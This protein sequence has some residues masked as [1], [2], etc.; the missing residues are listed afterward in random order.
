[1]QY[2]SINFQNLIPDLW[3]RQNHKLCKIKLFMMYQHYKKYSLIAGIIKALLE[4]TIVP[5]TNAMEMGDAHSQS[6]FQ[7]ASVKVCNTKIL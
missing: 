7:L 3:N 1:M 5:K 2:K 4:S 6:L